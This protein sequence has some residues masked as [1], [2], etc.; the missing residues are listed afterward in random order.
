[1]RAKRKSDH[2]LAIRSQA[3]RKVRG[4]KHH[5]KSVPKYQ[6]DVDKGLS[7]LRRVSSEGG[8]SR[9]KKAKNELM[10]LLNNYAPRFDHRIEQLID[11]WRRSGDPAYDPSIRVR[12][13]QVRR[14]HMNE[15][16]SL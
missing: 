8:D 12:L 7:N 15:G 10:Y 2:K 16:H 11:I 3:T 6:Q 5:P 1:M 9:A 13:R 4:P 14:A